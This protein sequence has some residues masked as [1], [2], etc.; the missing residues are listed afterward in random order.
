[1]GE[2]SRGI[3]LLGLSI[4]SSW[5]NGHAT[6][7]RSLVKGLARLGHSVLFLER[8]EPW[9]ATQRDLPDPAFCRVCLYDSLD[10]LDAVYRHEI[11]QADFV[12]V[13]SYVP[14]GCAV[15]DWALS[16]AGGK[17]AFYDID[18][19]VTL[20]KLQAGDHEYITPDLIRRYHMYLSF[21]GGST[22]EI[23]THTYGAPKA[24]ALYCSVDTDLYH[25]LDE[26]CVYDCGYMGTYSPDRQPSLQQ[27]LL[28][29][30][31]RLTQHRFVVAGPQ[32]PQTIMWPLNVQ[33]I[34]HLPPSSHCRFYNRQRFTLNVTRDDMR[35][36]GYS[37][38]VRL[39]EAA[40]CGVPIISDSW[41]GLETVFEPGSEILIS[42]SAEDTV[43]CL[44]SISD[45]ERQEIARRALGRIQAAHTSERRA[46]DLVDIMSSL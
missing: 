40:A 11:E 34:E 30:A 44:R 38:S 5:G 10:E 13:G 8:N 25:P 36:A 17:V 46:Q 39:F 6:T 9:Y 2:A 24:G 12:V 16:H 43:R 37:P 35:R 31:E 23:L 29:P 19:P 42:T 1:M 33:R 45:R 7:Y 3:V 41:D 32:Y 26:Y 21:T 18:T 27:L 14:E 28:E 15:G 22:L 4:T 20:A